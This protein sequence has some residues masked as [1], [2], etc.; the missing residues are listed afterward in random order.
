MADP[1]SVAASI[2][3]IVQAADQVLTRCYGYLG[4]VRSAAVDIDKAVQEISVLKG[5]LLNLHDLAQGEPN[6]ERLKLLVAPTGPLSIRAEV[7]QEIEAKLEPASTKLT[8]RR[9]C[10]WPFESRKLEEILERIRKQT[11]VLILAMVTDVAEIP[12]KLQTDVQ[13]IQ[14]SLKSAQSQGRYEKF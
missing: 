3:A 7:L 6:N 10:L 4:R 14:N 2:I 12:R 11:P 1:L 13:A 5:L 8:P 9:K